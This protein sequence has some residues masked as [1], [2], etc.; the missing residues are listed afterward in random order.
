[1]GFA[2]GTFPLGRGC[3]ITME[4]AEKETLRRA[5]ASLQRT[6]R[7][8]LACEP[9]V[10]LGAFA[11]T[12]G[13]VCFVRDD[14]LES[15]E[16]YTLRIS[17]ERI[18]IAY[19]AG[20]GAFRAV[21]TLGQLIIQHGRAIP[22]VEVADAPDFP[23]RGLLF[24]I[25][26][27]RLPSMETLRR[28]I[29]LLADMK[30]NQLQLYVEGF[31]FAYP[32]H[33]E[34]WAGE[35][36]LTG[37]EILTLDAYCAERCIELVPCQNTLGHMTQWLAR[38]EYN[39]LAECPQGYPAAWVKEGL[40]K[41]GTLNPASPGARALVAD[42]T[43]DLLPYFSSGK[44][45]VCL[46]EPYEL[47]MGA[48]KAAVD[49]EGQ[50]PVYLDYLR[51]VH[52]LCAGHGKRMMFWGDIVSRHPELIGEVPKDTI[53]LEW[54]YAKN[55]PFDE[56][57]EKYHDAG[58][59]YYVCPGTSTWRSLVG[60]YD[61][62]LGNQRNAAVGGLKHGAAG[63]LNTDWGDF[64]HWQHLPASY[65]GIAYGA[66][67][68][69]GV[70]TNLGLDLSACVNRFIYQDRSD[71]LGQLL[72]TIGLACEPGTRY[73]ATVPFSA[74][75]YP[76]DDMDAVQQ[77]PDLDVAHMLSC[78]DAFEKGLEGCDLAC[79]DA[80]VVLAELHQ[81]ADM[82]RHGYRAFALKREIHAHEGS[83]TPEMRRTAKDLYD[84]IARIIIDL[85]ATWLLRN[86]LGGL[87]RSLSRL[88][89]LQAAYERMIT[90]DGN[91]GVYGTEN[92]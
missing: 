92:A 17:P 23:V 58:L 20:V 84:D 46:D 70:Q 1:M 2:E 48:N 68:S 21:S 22:C 40:E 5:V 15:D 38:P 83:V 43:E 13:V 82:L 44:Y 26:R 53:L 31:S 72:H 3:A 6:C 7:K 73:G 78:V 51:Y 66:A 33:P 67:L 52:A 8:S 55:S 75:V 25:S 14:T 65:P 71:T 80:P 11:P 10:V 4:T 30:L 69:W 64:G 86:R 27:D 76:L 74:L 89:T 47:G 57:G 88:R 9:P 41:P 91:N 79:E 29:D 36:P 54:G 12:K 24:D 81:S 49:R 32:S 61:I 56:N 16:A 37:Q 87:E 77:Y 42:M 34:V 28:V 63:Y 35:T 90:E 45:N 60:K 19:R 85:Q 62:M 50:G 39:P 18:G 59:T